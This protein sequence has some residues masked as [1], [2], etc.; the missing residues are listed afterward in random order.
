MTSLVQITRDPFCRPWKRSRRVLEEARRRKLSITLAVDERSCA[1]CRMQAEAFHPVWFTPPYDSCG[2][3]I[4]EM[5][6]RAR[7]PMVLAVSDDE[8][9]S[10]RLWAFAQRPPMRMNWTVRLIT[11]T[12]D[13]RLYMRGTEI[14]I[15]L[16][17]LPEWHWIGGISGYDEHGKNVG[18][19][20]LVMWHFATFAPREV[21]EAKLR[22][23]QEGAKQDSTTPESQGHAEWKDYGERHFWED[24]PDMIVPMPADLKV[25]YPK[26]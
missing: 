16:M 6:H 9:P 24:R 7:E 2:P 18:A 14:Q 20:Q 15:R 11:P 21:R 8:E 22:A 4:E 12:P 17:Y 3:V 1:D 19:S 25:Q 23:Y 13:G 5:V 10:Q 26:A